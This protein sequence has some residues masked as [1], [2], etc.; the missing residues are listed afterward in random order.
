M[1]GRIFMQLVLL[2]GVLTVLPGC[3]GGKQAENPEQMS[4]IV[5]YEANWETLKTIKAPQW[6]DDA[7]FGIMIHWGPYAVAGF[8]P[9]GKGYAEWYP[10][11]MYENR[12]FQNYHENNFGPVSEV[13]YKDLIPMFK[14][15][16]WD[17]QAW[18]NLFKQAGA[19]YVVPVAEHHDGFAMWDSELTTWDAME[20][21]PKRDIIGELEKACRDQGLRYAPSYHRERHPSYFATTKYVVKSEPFPEIDAEIKN[22]PEAAELYGPFSYSDAF[23]ADYVARWKEI[24]DKYKPD[25]MWLDDIP[26]FYMVE[27]ERNHPQV[28]KYKQACAGMIADYFNAAQKWG[29]AVYLNNKGRREPNWPGGIGARSMDNMKMSVFPAPNWENPA[30]IAHSYGYNRIEEQMGAYGNSTA[31]IQLMADV[32]SK[33]GSLLLNVGPR[34]DGTIPQG[35]KQVLL[36]I[37]EWLKVN[38]EAIYGTR[39]WIQFGENQSVQGRK[40]NYRFTAKP[41]VVYGIA[42]Q[43]DKEPILLKAFQGFDK[44]IKSISSLSTG[45]SVDWQMQ[46]DG[47]QIL[48]PKRQA[49]KHAAVYKVTYI[50]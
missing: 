37:G 50:E 25:M 16:H 14:A 49:F 13:G 33:N 31:K 4:R 44:K 6:Y 12:D 36:D 29:K 39:P 26:V 35:Q 9:N 38:G 8:S 47:L 20:R 2:V 19:K 43:D 46:S 48:P 27:S 30:T 42:F 15:E 21:G 32:V 17:P 34:A 10:R 41:G 28:A 24:Q 3:A 40:L 7:K 22:M 18:A 23:I 1:N 5:P 11:N 45:A